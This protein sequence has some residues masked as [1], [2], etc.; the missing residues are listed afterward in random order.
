MKLLLTG[1]CGFA[2][3]ALAL[4]LLSR[5][6]GLDIIGVDNLS[7]PGSE[8]N[9]QRLKSHGVRFVH[10]D[11]RNPSDLEG[12]PKVDWVID[13]AANPSVLAGI[14]GPASSRQLM[15]HNLGGTLHVLEYCKRHR[16]GLVMLSTSRVYSLER[17]CALPLEVRDGA[18][19]PRL[20]GLHGAGVSL[21]GVNEDF[22]TQPPISLYGAAKLAAEVLML[23]YGLAFDFPVHINRCGVL[24]GAGQFGKP[25][26]GI[27]AFWIHSY[28]R[29]RPLKYIGFGGTGHQ[30]R[31]CLHPRDLSA[32]VALQ[33][34]GPA[35]AGKVLNVSG[36]VAN[37]MSLAR[38]SQWC[39]RRFGRQQILGDPALRPYDVP[40]L[41]L[42]SARAAAEW[43][44]HPATGLESILDELARHA[45]EHPGW[46]DLSS[47]T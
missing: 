3:S 43:Y 42:D 44:W 40:W 35:K 34:Q 5:L 6:Q 23:E 17:L 45:E 38:L 14:S 19:T 11:I 16:A 39:A 13:A 26:Q 33:L 41:V 22:P 28:C 2:G 37:S 27:F 7:R 25:D 46:L 24:A 20:D 8:Q 47:D 15:E 36:G 4:E 12:L 9:R 32:L 30:V 21:A 10:G 1:I 29:K 31:D 18:F